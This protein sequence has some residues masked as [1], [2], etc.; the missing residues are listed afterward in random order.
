MSK[1]TRSIEKDF[2]VISPEKSATI[3][4]F[5]STL[6]ERLDKNYG[7]FRG[8]ELISCYEFSEDWSTWEMHPKGDEVVILLSGEVTLV[9]QLDDGERSVSLKKIGEYAIVP[10]C[11]WHTAKTSV[12]TKMLFIT[13]GE[14]TQNKE[15]LGADE[16]YALDN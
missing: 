16:N 8:C 14:G 15:F 4:S 5:D 13:P 9:M 12:K 6:Y 10:K 1:P 11:T 3:E 7:G 2:V